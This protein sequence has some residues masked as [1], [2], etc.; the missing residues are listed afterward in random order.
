MGMP[1]LNNLQSAPVTW[2]KE[3]RASYLVEFGQILNA[4]GL[5]NGYLR[6]RLDEA[7]GRYEELYV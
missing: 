6:R 4:L 2:T 3:T 1:S 5:V 7:M